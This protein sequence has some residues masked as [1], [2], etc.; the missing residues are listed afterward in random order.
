MG[1]V[2]WQASDSPLS[3]ELHGQSLN[4]YS[5]THTP[6]RVT[7]GRWGKTL[8]GGNLDFLENLDSTKQFALMPEPAQNCKTIQFFDQK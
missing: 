7:S 1:G 3:K 6:T 8:F 4:S 5:L 2:I